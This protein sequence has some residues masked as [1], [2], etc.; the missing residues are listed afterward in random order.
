[1]RRIEPTAIHE[2]PCEVMIRLIGGG[3]K[4]LLVYHLATKGVQ[5]YAD[6][7]RLMPGISP[8][9]LTQQLRALEADAIVERTVYPEV[10]P[11]VEYQLTPLGATLR[12]VIDAMYAWG[13][14]HGQRSAQRSVV[15]NATKS[16]GQEK[17]ESQISAD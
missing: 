1:M 17:V 6:L 8:K 2:C 5:R 9:I 13:M 12:P 14:Q 7:R 4:V 11:R 3:W 10:P 15:K 16:T